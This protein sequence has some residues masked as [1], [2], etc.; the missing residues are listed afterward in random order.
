MTVV[1]KIDNMFNDN[2]LIDVAGLLYIAADYNENG[3]KTWPE[4]DGSNNQTSIDEMASYN[5]D[6]VG[7]FVDATKSQTQENER[8]I[9]SDACNR[10]EIAASVDVIT[11]FTATLQEMGNIE[12][13]AR[14][15]G[16]AIQETPA[17]AQTG[18]KLDKV[19]WGY[20]E[21]GKVI[22]FTENT[23]G[24]ITSVTGSVDGALTLTTDYTLETDADGSIGIELV[25]GWTITTLDQTF[26]VVY[27]QTPKAKKQLVEK[28]GQRTLPYLLLRF[29]QCEKTGS[30]EKNRVHYFA[31]ARISSELTVDFVN[32]SRNDFAG[33]TVTFTVAKDGNYAQTE[34]TNP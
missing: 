33:S 4:G 18:L 9:E 34:I 29:V 19:F 15:L 8:V 27:D 2:N 17:V 21:F 30:G 25:A 20:T 5:F 3:S 26:T 14:I 10:E 24:S 16:C 13:M 11:T 12:L 6:E 22:D 7:F 28:N 31:K 23:A 32:Q 1:K